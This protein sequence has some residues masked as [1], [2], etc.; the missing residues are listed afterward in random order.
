MKKTILSILSVLTISAGLNAQIVITEQGTSTDIAGGEINSII[1]EETSLALQNDH[2]LDLDVTNNSGASKS[3]LITRVNLINP[4]G[5][6]ETI[7]WGDPLAG[8]VCY[9]HSPNDPWE[10]GSLT[11]TDGNSVQLS[12]YVSNPGSGEMAHYRYYVTEGTTYIDSVDWVINK[13]ASIKENKELTLNVSPNPANDV[14]NLNISA[15]ANVR[16]VDVLGNVVLNDKMEAGKNSLDVSSFKNGVYFV[17]IEAEGIKPT[18][19]KVIIRH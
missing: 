5:F 7:C 2:I 8:G 18:T 13:S 17:M 15:A 16:M 1:T 10:S 11:V 19:R 9:P 14:M 12:L 3:V 6:E 4:T